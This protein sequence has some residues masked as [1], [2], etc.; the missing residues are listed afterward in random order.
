[1]TRH[2]LR[3]RIGVAIKLFGNIGI[4][5]SSM[6][7]LVDGEQNVGVFDFLRTAF[8]GGDQ[9]C[10]IDSFFGSQCDFVLFLHDNFLVRVRK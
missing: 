2:Y 8:P 5:D 1:M 10:E 4:E 6:F 7:F 3:I 9:G